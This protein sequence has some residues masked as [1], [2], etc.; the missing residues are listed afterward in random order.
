MIIVPQILPGSDNHEFVPIFIT[1]Q[2]SADIRTIFLRL[3]RHMAA[4]GAFG[5]DLRW[6]DDMSGNIFIHEDGDS[7]VPVNAVPRIVL[8]GGGGQNRKLG[9]SG[10]ISGTTGSGASNTVMS[11]SSINL[12]VTGRDKAEAGRLAEICN[13]YIDILTPNIKGSVVNMEAISNISWSAARKAA[14]KSGN[15]LVWKAGVS[16][17]VEYTKCYE[18]S[19]YKG[20]GRSPHALYNKGVHL[21]TAEEQSMAFEDSRPLFS[22]MDFKVTA[23]GSDTT[24]ELVVVHRTF[25]TDQDGNS[26]DMP[27]LMESPYLTASPS[28][29]EFGEQT[30][31]SY[32]ESENISV[33]PDTDGEQQVEVILPSG[34]VTDLIHNDA[35]DSIIKFKVV[36]K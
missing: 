3:L 10:T 30:A 20:M 29:I 36:K 2:T 27:E 23:G 28:L 5:R 14:E 13:D 17:T 6:S 35:L 12:E 1:I 19:R 15:P 21:G 16:F 7:N 11:L 33:T 32:S 18:T 8:S 4:R 31:G 24:D 9:M 34:A 25:I 26:I 22:L